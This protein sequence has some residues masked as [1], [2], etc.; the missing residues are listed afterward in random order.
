[1]FSQE[2][3]EI[4]RHAFIQASRRGITPDLIEKTI[5][6]G[7]QIR[8]G[9]NYIKFVGKSVICVGEIKGMK[10]KILTIVRK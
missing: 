8:F 5:L 3:M 7:K 6:T 9:K 10:I 2:D 4:S 1:M